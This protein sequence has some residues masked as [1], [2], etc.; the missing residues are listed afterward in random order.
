MIKLAIN[1]FGRIGRQSF[2]IAMERDDIDIVAINDLM[3]PEVLAHLLTYDSIYGIYPK[4][5]QVEVDGEIIDVEGTGNAKH[6][7]GFEEKEVYL[8][9]NDKKIRLYSIPNPKELPWGN[10]DV[11]VVLECT[12]IFTKDGKAGMHIE[13]G[14][15]QVI[16]SAPTKGDG[17]VGTYLMGVNHDTAS[18]ADSEV[19]KVIS[20]GSCTTNCVGP[21]TAVMMSHFG[22]QKAMM[23]TIH[24]YTASQMLVDG[25]SR[26]IH[27]Y[28]RMRAAAHNIVPTTTGAAISTTEA[29]PELKG[30]FD[31]SAI[32]V[33]SIVGS[34]TDFVFLTKRD[35]SIE[36]VNQAF[37]ETAE[38]N[39]MFDGVLEV[40][41]EPI[42]SSDIIGNPASAIVDL[43][44]TSVVDGNM[45]K[46]MAWYDNE[47]GY[48]TRLVEMALE[49]N[50]K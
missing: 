8:I 39:P 7:D 48:S 12:G 3:P 29:I 44:M 18:E 37:I 28:R 45:V 16:V 30:K 31:G 25:Y 47:V 11:D 6:I 10:H 23:T 1:G 50:R 27:D 34:I 2:K 15:K 21:V 32:R 22:I 49:V 43:Q 41:Y 9:I 17:G 35:V 14:A 33:P 36:E 40:T 20:N 46:V 5:V 19:G 13:A 4:D 42:V 24:S 26:N 38:K